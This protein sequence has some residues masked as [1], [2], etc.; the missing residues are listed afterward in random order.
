M[1]P[2]LTPDQIEAIRLRA[3][4]GWPTSH[5]LTDL[6][7]AYDY[8][9]EVAVAWKTKQRGEKHLR[10]AAEARL[11]EVEAEQETWRPVMSDYLDERDRHVQTMKRAVAAE[12][13]LAAVEAAL[14]SNE[15]CDGYPE[16]CGEADG[17]YVKAVIDKVRAAVRG[18]GDRAAE[19][20]DTEDAHGNPICV[21]PDL[22]GE[23]GRG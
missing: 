11:A 13:R 6:L 9:R 15:N 23:C 17:C 18:E 5:D 3:Q 21:C 22:R 16:E 1:T 4:G 19:H 7:A 8:K 20:Y 2:P 12:S 14:A 10:E